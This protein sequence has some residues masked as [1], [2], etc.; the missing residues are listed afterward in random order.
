[1]PCAVP[2]L[3]SA[4]AQLTLGLTGAR[5][6]SWTSCLCCTQHREPPQ[7]MHRI[8]CPAGP[9]LWAGSDSSIQTS[10]R[11]RMHVQSR[12]SLH[13]ALTP[14]QPLCCVQGPLHAGPET[15]S[16]C[17][18][19]PETHRPDHTAPWVLCLTPLPYYNSM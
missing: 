1:M 16:A 8:R 15:K 14:D 19:S 9:A 4:H 2:G 10:P 12:G 5:M 7:D 11:A 6:V 13:A 17:A 3:Q 18:V